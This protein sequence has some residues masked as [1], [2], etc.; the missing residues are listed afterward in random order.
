MHYKILILLQY[1]ENIARI[2]HSFEVQQGG[3][4][5]ACIQYI[6]ATFLILASYGDIKGKELDYSTTQIRNMWF[7]CSSVFRVNYPRIPEQIKIVLCDCYVNHLRETYS[8]KEVLELSKEESGKLGSEV[9]QACK[10]PELIII[11]ITS[12]IP[13]GAT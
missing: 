11:N 13:K 8:A 2:L 10:M 5:K 7:V 4:M 12:S 3:R 9:A 1:H 6:L